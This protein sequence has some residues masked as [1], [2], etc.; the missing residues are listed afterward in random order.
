MEIFIACVQRDVKKIKDLINNNTN[1]IYL[2]DNNGNTF[3]HLCAIYKIYDVLINTVKIYPELITYLNNEGKSLIHL[4]DDYDP[5]NF[6]I[7]LIISNNMIEELNT[8]PYDGR[9]LLINLLDKYQTNNQYLILINKLLNNQVKLDIPS[10]NPPLNY[11]IENNPDIKITS[12]LL[13]AGANP[14]L[15]NKYGL[16]TLIIAI[17]NNVNIDVIKLLLDYGVDINYSGPED[18]FLPLTI[19]LKKGYYHITEAL[20]NY[21]PDLSHQDNNMNTPLHYAILTKKRLPR[22]IIKYL[23]SNSDLNIKNINGQTPLHFLILSKKWD[24][25]YK[26]I[27]KKELDLNTVDNN[28]NTPISYMNGL[29]YIYI[30]NT[31]SNEILRNK[32]IEKCLNNKKT[33]NYKCIE[34]LRSIIKE[35]LLSNN[36]NIKKIK[37]PTIVE[38]DYGIFGNNVLYNIIY[39]IQILKKY[40]NTFIPFQYFIPEKCLDCI[41]K[42]NNY[43]L[44]RTKY[45]QILHD[46]LEVYIESFFEIAPS[47]IIWHSKYVNYHN[48]DLH[49]YIKKLLD[50]NNIRFVIIKLTIITLKNMNHANIILYDKKNNTVE[51][52]EPYGSLN[53]YIKDIEYLD[54]YLYEIFRNCINY[55]IIYKSPHDYM[56]KVKFQLISS[57]SEPENQKIGDPNGY[58]L[59]W[60]YWFLELKFKNP[61]YDTEELIKDTLIEMIKDG[62]NENNIINHI[63]KY[64]KKLDL[65]KNQFLISIGFKNNELYNVAYKIDKLEILFNNLSKQFNEM[66]SERI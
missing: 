64:G 50:S 21:N 34:P 23:I 62:R 16:N 61:N 6:I 18:K 20:I 51:R 32:I 59:A 13:K 29:D 53:Y 42:L 33:I 41:M 7:D 1:I 54:Q 40:K 4:I 60:C 58:C 10:E 2:S 17:L 3:G 37:F 36:K 57:E 38:T 11:I 26:F 28:N 43:N 9:T 49:I 35:D 30:I 65:L 66:V 39:L 52:F 63:R 12:L 15:K 44:Y 31:V 46:I 22:K 19:S 47:I 27:K 14:N 8:I 5:L 55:D 56:K 24:Q 48:P 25:Y 45:G